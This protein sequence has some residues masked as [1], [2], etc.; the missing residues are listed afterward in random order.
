M[1]V[2]LRPATLR[3]IIK[4]AA[5]LVIDE[6]KSH[7][8]ESKKPHHRYIKGVR[9]ATYYPGNL[10][11]SL[12]IIG[13][14]GKLTGTVVAGPRRYKGDPTG[15]FKGRRVDGYYAGIVEKKRP[16]LRPAFEAKKGQAE[17]IITEGLKNELE[18][19]IR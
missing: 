8:S 16:Y 10:K 11:R 1:N 2:I 7:V 15:Q 4:P 5:Q 19:A 9:V 12:Q 17:K 3:N 14:L 13:N 6:A 18:N